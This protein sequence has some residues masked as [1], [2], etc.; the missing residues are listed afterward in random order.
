MPSA[1]VGF[2]Q[3]PPSWA[4]AMV[5]GFWVDMSEGFRPSI[6][7]LR[8]FG[9]QKS[10]KLHLETSKLYEKVRLLFIYGHLPPAR[11]AS[12]VASGLFAVLILGKKQSALVRYTWSLSAS[13]INLAKV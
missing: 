7:Q 11:V 9:N 8:F 6:F 3:R 13:V 4:T 5:K 10:R 1:V 12:G 2:G